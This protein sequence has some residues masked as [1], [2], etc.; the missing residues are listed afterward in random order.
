MNSLLTIVLFSFLAVFYAHAGEMPLRCLEEGYSGLGVH[1]KGSKLP[2]EKEGSLGLSYSEEG[3]LHVFQGYTI[4]YVEED[5]LY[6]RW[7]GL[8]SIYGQ[9]YFFPEEIRLKVHSDAHLSLEYGYASSIPM[10]C[11]KL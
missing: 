4:S 9:S 10:Y 11:K 1:Y 5:T 7:E 8:P 6:L 3:S 2:L